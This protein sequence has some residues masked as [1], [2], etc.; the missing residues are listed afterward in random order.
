MREGMATNTMGLEIA[1]AKGKEL[2]EGFFDPTSAWFLSA[3]VFGR[4]VGMGT[5]FRQ[6]AVLAGNSLKAAKEDPSKFYSLERD[7][8]PLIRFVSGRT[9]P[10]TSLLWD[11]AT[12]KD[13]LGDPLTTPEAIGRRVGKSVVP[14][15]AQEFVPEPGQP[16]QR[17]ESV[18]PDI[19]G[20]RAVPLSTAQ[21]RDQKIAEATGEKKNWGDLDTVDRWEL[22]QQHPEIKALVEQGA[23]ERARRGDIVG[24]F[25]QAVDKMREPYFDQIKTLTEQAKQN[26]ISGR[27]YRDELRRLEG[28]IAEAPD[29]LKRDPHYASVPMTDEEKAAYY[30]GRVAPQQSP[31]DRFLDEYYGLAARFTDPQTKMVDVAQLVQAQEKL[32]AESDPTVVERA[33]RYINRNRDP[34]YV[35]AL[36]AY[37]QYQAIPRYLGVTLEDQRQVDEAARVVLQ[38]RNLAPAKMRPEDRTDWATRQAMQARP[39]LRKWIVHLPELAK[40]DR[41]NPK[42]KAFWSSNSGLLERYFGAG[43]PEQGAGVQTKQAA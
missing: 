29:M 39:E 35:K 11:A 26:K 20:M 28:L 16:A 40:A 14:M 25:W 34:E 3:D 24:Q 37:R 15:W 18:I 17:P 4:R 22:Q 31:T 19:L 38:Y 12:G 9:A 43:L 8:N 21:R 36:E 42:R 2:P 33:T 13:F 30:K 6:L 23:E 5:I 10:V 27:Q 41:R 32:K 7:D 1:R